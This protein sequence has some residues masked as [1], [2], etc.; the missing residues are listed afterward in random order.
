MIIIFPKYSYYTA[1]SDETKSSVRAIIRKV[2]DEY[3]DGKPMILLED[4]LG[5]G[6]IGE[7]SNVVS[8]TDPR[9][10]SQML[11]FNYYEQESYMQ[12]FYNMYPR[13]VCPFVKFENP[14]ISM[15]MRNR[16]EY[17]TK[18]I[19]AYEKRLKESIKYLAEKHKAVLTFVG[20]TNSKS[21]FEIKPEENDGILNIVY[22]LDTNTVNCYYSGTWIDSEMAK[23]ILGGLHG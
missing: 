14:P 13:D 23:Q 17:V 8:I 5:K 2:I 19:A 9:D 12:E 3:V 1:L 20:N 18:R 22:S 11:A 6:L 21:K 15:S 16:E 10:Y 7:N 4:S